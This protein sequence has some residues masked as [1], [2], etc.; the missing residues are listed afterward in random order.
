MAMKH[1]NDLCDL[2]GGELAP[3]T[4][5]L[6]IWRGP[7]L[8]VLKDISADVCQQCGEAYFSPET[9]EKIDRFLAEYKYYRPIQSYPGTRIFGSPDDV[10]TTRV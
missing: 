2:C 5:T 3:G 9:S 4:T 1:Q 8:I 10:K 6:E 7:E